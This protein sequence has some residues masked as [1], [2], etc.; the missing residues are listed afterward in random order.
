MKLSELLQ[1]DHTVG[2]QHTI[3]T[4]KNANAL[5]TTNLYANSFTV[6]LIIIMQAKLT[7][8]FYG[9]KIL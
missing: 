5:L 9:I 4:G 3:N 6:E 7:A 2:V 8:C 1:S